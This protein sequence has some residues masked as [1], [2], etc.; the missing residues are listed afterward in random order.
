M[1]VW[2][3]GW[4]DGWMDRQMGDWEDILIVEQTNGWMD[5]QINEWE[6]KQLNTN[7]LGSQ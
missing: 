2:M 5:R 7:D 3:D 6:A 1:H 4:M